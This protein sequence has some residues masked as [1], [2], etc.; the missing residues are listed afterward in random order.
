MK[1]TEHALLKF[2]TQRPMSK[3]NSTEMPD[4][5]TIAAR[6]AA[7]EVIRSVIIRHRSLGEA[8]GSTPEYVSLSVPDRGF[9]AFIAR[10]ALRRLGQ[11][12]ALINHCVPDALPRKARP[13]RDV[14]RVGIAQLLFSATAPHAAVSTTVDLCRNI[15]QVPF[16][17]LVNAVMRRLQRE[18]EDLLTAQDAARLNTPEW[19]WESWVA[20][21][22]EE[23][24]RAIAAAHLETPPVDLTPKSD[25]E[26]WAKTLGGSLVLGGSVRMTETSD[27]TALE[28]FAEGEWWVQDA[29]ARLPV[30]LL[31]DIQGKDVIDLCAAPGGKTMELLAHGG[32]VT[33]V[34]ISK[35]RLERVADNLG[36]VSYKA[37]LVCADVRKWKPDALADVVL[38][39]A[40]CSSTGT[41][42]RHPDLIHLKTPEDILKLAVVQ[43]NLLD[44][45]AAFLKPGGTL[46]FVTCSLLAEEGPERIIA[47]L[48]NNPSFTRKPITTN[49]MPG[50]SDAITLKGD[51]RTLPHFLRDQGGMDGFFIARLVKGAA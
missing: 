38:V 1:T 37:E 7:F 49:E 11:I 22:G 47:F 42:R 10:M 4:I 43:D 12:D 33:A 25:P 44:A 17:K 8:F 51:V 21:Y 6:R 5:R 20:A 45:A 29:A 31:G 14:L 24:A 26:K 41:M 35:R 36:R 16:A 23:T 39:D 15:E 34:D 3:Q 50:L 13:V 40:P 32:N 28:G 48:A 30:T 9:A 18:G 27:V 46:M 2:E 19:L